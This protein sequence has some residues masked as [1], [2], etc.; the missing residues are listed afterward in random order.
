[1]TNSLGKT[2]N[3]TSKKAEMTS[4]KKDNSKVAVILTQ[5]MAI[6]DFNAVFFLFFRSKQNDSINVIILYSV[7]VPIFILFSCIHIG[8]M[9]LSKNCTKES[10]KLA[11]VIVNLVLIFLLILSIVLYNQFMIKWGQ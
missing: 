5:I 4:P 1:M 10:K 7:Y 6:L 2:I 8:A 9:A 3:E 11:I